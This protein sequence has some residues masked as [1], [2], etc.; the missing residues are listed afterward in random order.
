MK[1]RKIT[2]LTA[3]LSFVLMVLTSVVLY[4]V[5]QGRVAYWADW[6]LLGMTKTDW[7]NIHINLGLLFLISL[8]LHIYYNW[9]AL[10]SYLKNKTKQIKVFTPEFSLAL[11][12]TIVAA[13][14]TYLMVPPFSW[15]MSLNDHFKDSG[16]K[17]YG[18]PPYGHAELSSLK[19]F[20]KKMNLDLEKSMEL[21]KQAG[22]VVTDSTETLKTIGDQNERSPQ[23]VYETIKPAA[24]YTTGMSKT[25][26]AL[27]ES[28]Q[29]GTGRLT[30]ADFCAQ[31]GLNNKW[32]VRELKRHAIEA[33]EE[34]TLK[35]IA[36]QSN[37]SSIELYERIKDI[38]NKG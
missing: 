37:L 1:I 15:V 19:T 2:S 30:L 21:L 35:T 10:I 11:A 3:S 26:T 23:Q 29:P 24:K 7:G 38:V 36:A 22:Y 6:H 20:A 17:K 14:G 16:T 28:P 5:P 4:I 31:Y 25:E 13:V 34:L 12:I 18:E 8:L 9:K 32:I 27:P 33:S